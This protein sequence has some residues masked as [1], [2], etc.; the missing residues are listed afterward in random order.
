MFIL[1]ISV[2]FAVSVYFAIQSFISFVS[3]FELQRKIS[4]K[5]TQTKDSFQFKGITGLLFFLGQKLGYFI[6]KKNYDKLNKL[7]KEIAGY[8]SVLGKPYNTIQPYTY[9]SFQIFAGFGLT[10]FLSFILSTVNIAL[11]LIFMA[12]GFFMPYYILKEKVK[13][14]HK[15]IFR[16]IPDILDLLTLMIE[17]GLDFN[18]ALNRI[19]TIEKGELVDE[20]SVVLQEIKLGKPRMEAYSDMSKRIN[21][22]PLSSVIS[23]ITNALNTGGSMGNTFRTLSAQFR[24][25]RSQLAEKLAGEAPLKLMF[26]LVIFI[27]PTIFIVIFGPIIISFMTTGGF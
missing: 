21:Y 23:S 9:V 24:I 6:E 5:I 2:L 25:E 11:L 13:D 26:P 10:L 17:A 4:A 16:Q 22:T 3:G 20:F 14:K 19:V 15:A 8:T 27:F 7:T 18:A 12:L 1:L